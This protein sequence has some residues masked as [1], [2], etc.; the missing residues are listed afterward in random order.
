MA[1]AAHAPLAT[2]RPVVEEQVETGELD[3]RL[4]ET[5]TPFVVCG[6]IAD[7][8]LVKAGLDSGAAARAYLLEHRRD[9]AFTVNIGEPGAG[10][11]L[12]YDEAMA[13]NFRTG[14]ADLAEIFAGIAANQG[15]PDAPAI[16]LPSCDLKYYFDALHDAHPHDLVADRQ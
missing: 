13:M 4:A 3:S 7:W 14:R 6:L 2:P 9:R 11:R 12:F 8:A 5:R 10:D 16:Y 15:R 1:D